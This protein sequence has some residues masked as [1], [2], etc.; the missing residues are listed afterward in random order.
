MTGV[1]LV[2]ITPSTLIGNNYQIYF[3]SIV[4]L[5]IRGISY[6]RKTAFTHP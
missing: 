3:P 4:A 1:L 2:V 5:S 6:R